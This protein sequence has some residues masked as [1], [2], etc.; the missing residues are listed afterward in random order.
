MKAS[1]LTTSLLVDQTPQ[2]VFTAINN[3]S[4]WWTEI[5]GSSKELHDVFTVRFGQVFITHKIVELVPGQKVV[6]HVTDSNV[7]E[8][9][10]TMIRFEI[11]AKNNSTEI[12]FTHIGMYPGLEDY[13]DCV[14][15]WNK[16]IHEGLFNL[17][18]RGDGVPA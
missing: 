8:W 10:D 16:F 9:V 3:V 7:K 4:G 1:N 6:W 2:E 12:H 14:K 17:I 11:S 5:K 18:T 15:G 13:D